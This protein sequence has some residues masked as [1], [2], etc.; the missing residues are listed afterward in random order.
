MKG[1]C[2]PQG[3]E[4]ESWCQLDSFLLN[5]FLFL[6]YLSR[7][8]KLSKIDNDLL[9]YERWKVRVKMLKNES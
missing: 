6:F 2:E 4:F 5:L 1:E 9:R 8:V 7:R 3:Y